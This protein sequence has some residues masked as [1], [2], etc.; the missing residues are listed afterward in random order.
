MNQ[1]KKINKEELRDVS[2]KNSDGSFSMENLRDRQRKLQLCILLT[3]HAA[4]MAKIVF[5][6]IEG[7]REVKAAVWGATTKYILLTGGSFIPVESVASVSLEQK[8]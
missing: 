8:P 6:T 7:Y 4:G 3:E 5:N 2:F 1:T